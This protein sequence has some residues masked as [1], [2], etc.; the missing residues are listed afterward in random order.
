MFLES[1]FYQGRHCVLWEAWEAQN[2]VLTSLGLLFLLSYCGLTFL[3]LPN[4]QLYQRLQKGRY[5][6]NTQN[7]SF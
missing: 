4:P 3:R 7:V 2:H 1:H 5:E 6:E